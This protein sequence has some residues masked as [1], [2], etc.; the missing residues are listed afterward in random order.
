MP[1]VFD[2]VVDETDTLGLLRDTPLTTTTAVDDGTL[3]TSSTVYVA[4]SL[5]IGYPLMMVIVVYLCKI[6]MYRF[7]PYAGLTYEEVSYKTPKFHHIS[8][9]LKSLHWLKINDRIKYKVFSHTYKSLSNW[10]TFLPLLNSSFIPFRSL[11]SV[12]FS[13]HPSSPY[14][15]LSS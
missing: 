14:S 3:M 7:G 8:P 4:L 9:I 11:Y 15:H 5:S 2:K 6:Y 1:S 10:S 13:Y 12:F